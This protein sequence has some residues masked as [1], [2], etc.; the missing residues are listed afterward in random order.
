MDQAKQGQTTLHDLAMGPRIT[1]AVDRLLRQANR[2]WA[3]VEPATGVNEPQARVLSVVRGGARQI[4][5]VAEA[6]GRHVS[7]ASRL[8][9]QLVRAGHLDRVE[10]TE[11]RRAVVVSLTDRG[12]EVLA[13][14]EAAHGAFLQQALE[15]LGPDATAELASALERLA[16]A[17]DAEDGATLVVER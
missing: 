17:L 7:T 10:D 5:D 1:L 8:V 14:I 11:D 9:E 6:C 16:D 13:A 12:E 4:S 3:E 15:R 2:N